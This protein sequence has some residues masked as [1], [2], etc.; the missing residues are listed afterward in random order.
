MRRLWFVV[1]VLLAA[2]QPQASTHVSPSSTAARS[3]SQS[4]A[5]T[6]S[7][8]VYVQ[9]PDGP[10]MLQMDWAG[11][12]VGSVPAQGFE[13]PSPDGSRYIRSNGQEL[14]AEDR[15]GHSLGR[16]SDRPSSGLLVWADDGVHLCDIVFP[17]YTGPDSGQ[18]SLWIGAPGE[19]GRIVGPAG[20]R[21][22]N[23]AVVACSIRDNRA[24]VAGGLM[25]HWP[26]GATRYLISTDVA[27]INLTT[28]AVEYEHQYPLGNLGA[29]GEVGPRGDWVL[30]TPSPDGRYLAEGAV[31]SDTAAIREV[32]TGTQ[33]ASLRGSVCGLSWNGSRVVMNV[34]SGGSPE[35]RVVTWVDQQIIWH[36]P[37]RCA[38]VLARPKSSDL[39]IG[40]GSNELYALTDGGTALIS[41]NAYVRWPCPCHPGP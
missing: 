34:T 32:P 5:A 40:I 31:F 28:G 9:D 15:N 17:P 33:L 41:N 39:L 18:G 1:P 13:D 2:C 12:V 8:V 25:P 14:L 7:D 16:L 24:L 35:V 36:R 10:R 26:A 19:Q 38:G 22:S 27:A 11:K 20:K 37:G 3:P 21:G 4:A 29:Q 6:Y 23:P 30:V